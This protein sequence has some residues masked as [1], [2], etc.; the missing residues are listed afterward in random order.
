MN[1]GIVKETKP[2]EGR[3]AL[4]PDGCLLLIKQQHAVFIEQGAGQLSG[5]SDEQYR[6]IGVTV[7]S[8]AEQLYH[9]CELIVKVKEP[10]AV[11]L[12][13]L[14]DK[15]TLFCF[16]HLAA[17]PKLA[18]QLAGKGL[19]A[20][21][22]ESV[23]ENKQLPL[24]KPMSQIAGRLAV[25]IGSNL[26]HLQQG[27]MGLLLGGIDGSSEQ[28][29]VGRGQVLV[30][31]AGSAG[32]QAALLAS[33]MG[34]KVFVFDRYVEALNQLKKHDPTIQVLTEEDV[35]RALLA[36]TNL[37]VAALLIPGKRSPR[38]I[39]REQLKLM[40]KAS[41]LVDISVDQGGCVETTRPTSYQQPTY[42]E[43]GVLHFCVSNMPG[44]VPR[45]AS[46]V[47]SALLPA[48]I[49]RLTLKNWYENDNIMHDA[50]NIKGGDVLVDV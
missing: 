50:V 21:A 46:Q 35:C 44:A 43:E 4:L 16:L 38:F 45:T 9:C 14:T 20:V 39:S 3:V 24:L 8:T 22:Y 48:Y 27:G 41:V 12:E 29:P 23:M 6:Q 17:N 7:C 40:P 19:T 26:L 33:K 13:H 37:L 2:L 1:I 31:G 10:T 15:H 5:Y 47:L 25:Q 42:I 11:D 18:D 49:H 30:L 32:T 28:G 34:A 36:T